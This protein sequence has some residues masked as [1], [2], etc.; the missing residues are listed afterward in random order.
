[1]STTPKP[2]AWFTVEHTQPYIGIKRLT[3]VGEHFQIEAD[4]NADGS[5]TVIVRKADCAILRFEH[6]NPHGA[7]REL[8]HIMARS[9][10]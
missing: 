4:Q 3:I 6:T 9:A 10:Q 7:A 1:M 8:Q 2:S 5:G